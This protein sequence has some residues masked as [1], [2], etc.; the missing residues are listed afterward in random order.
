MKALKAGLVYFAVVFGAG[1]GLG[2]MR[3]LWLEPRFGT[4]WAELAESP[5]MLVVMVLAARWIVRRFDVPRVSAARLVMG[6]SALAFMQAAEF[7][8]VLSLRGMTIAQ[9]LAVRDPVSGA[10]YYL[11]LAVLALLPLLLA[12]GG[13]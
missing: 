7:G 9:Y 3:V 1:F 12:R 8:L 6:F 4:R 10:V 11:L 2:F 5:V 13:R